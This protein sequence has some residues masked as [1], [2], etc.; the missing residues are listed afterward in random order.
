MLCREHA[1]NLVPGAGEFITQ[2]QFYLNGQ[3]ALRLHYLTGI[4]FALLGKELHRPQYLIP[5]QTRI[6][7]QRQHYGQ[8]MAIDRCIA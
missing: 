4:I 1:E 8:H 2:Q 7:E 3:Q 6:Y 5:A